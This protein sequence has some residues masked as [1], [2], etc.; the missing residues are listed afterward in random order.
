MD[1]YILLYLKWIPNKGLLWSPQ[2]SAQ[3]YVGTWLGG[4]FGGEWMHVYV[5]LSLCCSPETL[6]IM[7]ISFT[8]IQNLKKKKGIALVRCSLQFI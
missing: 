3:C 4:E 6:T 8:P 7:L 5:W 1:M 2:N